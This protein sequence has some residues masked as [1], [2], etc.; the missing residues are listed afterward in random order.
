[1]TEIKQVLYDLRMSYNGPFLV[2]ELYKEVDS[3]IVENGFEKEHKKKMEHLTKTGKKIEWVTDIHSHLDE[4][5][6]GSIILRIQMDNIKHVT[7]KKDG[8][9]YSINNGDVHVLV[10]GFIYGHMY[11][12]FW[13]TRP[14]YRF[15]RTLIDRYIYNYWTDRFDGV[16]NTQGRELFKRIQSFFKL[17]K[18]KYA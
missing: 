14:I 5:N 11:G 10:E 2:E 13:A 17:Q 1:M 6:H 8:K 18:Y 7:I 12:T 3:W 4:Y 9:K 16:V 15:F